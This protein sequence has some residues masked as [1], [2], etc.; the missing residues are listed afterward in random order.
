MQETKNQEKDYRERFEFRFTVKNNE[1]GEEYII[2]QRYFKILGFNPTCE[3]SY[4]LVDAIRTC[5][6]AIDADLKSKTQAY[7]EIFA[8]RYFDTE[9]EMNSYFENPAHRVKMRL[10][11]GIVVRNNEKF[12]YFWSDKGPR[13]LSFKFDDGELA[14]PIG[15]N[16]VLTYKL[17]FCDN[18]RE[19]CSTIWSG[20]YPRYIR[21]SIDIS[22][23]RGRFEG[24]DT[25]HLS[26]EQYLLFQLSKGRKDLVYWIIREI[27]NAC[28]YHGTNSYTTKDEYT[29][30]NGDVVTYKNKMR[31]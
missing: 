7:L 17:S 4:E 24:D 19:V 1:D 25:S 14:Q 13:A 26:F 2:C 11:E 8:P 6:E 15:P 12:D 30:P 18:E 22:N 9:E 23:K 16:D 21:N 10:G 20:V 3:R 5:A 29:L 28:T 27:C 31:G